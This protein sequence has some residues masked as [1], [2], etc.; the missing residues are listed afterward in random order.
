MARD[1]DYKAALRRLQ[2][3]LVKAA[4]TTIRQ[5]EQLIKQGD[6]M[7][8]VVGATGQVKQLE[9]ALNDNLASLAQ[10]HNFEETVMKLATTIQLLSARL[11]R[12]AERP[13]VVDLTGKKPPAH[14]A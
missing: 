14:A 3:A 6:V 13:P 9:E 8:Q 7:L 5:Q 11:S 2:V 4:E 12:G 1:K 10:A